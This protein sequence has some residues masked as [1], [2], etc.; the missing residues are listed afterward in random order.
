MVNYNIYVN[1]YRYTLVAGALF[2]TVAVVPQYRYAFLFFFTLVIM[3]NA[4]LR[5]EYFSYKFKLVSIIADVVMVLYMDHFFKGF[6]YLLLLVTLVDLMLKLKTEAFTIF[7]IVTGAYGY[8]VYKT[9]TPELLFIV[10][11][12]YIVT[13]LLL[14]HL[15]KEMLSKVDTEQLYDQI[16]KNNYEMEAAR[17]RLLDYSRQVERITKLEERNRISR[18][19]HDSIGHSLTG[20]FMQVDASIQLLE[21]DREKGMEVLRSAHDNINNAIESVRNTVRRIRPVDYQNYA[22][23]LNDLVD[24]FRKTTGVN[25]ELKSIGMPYELFP[26]METV[27]FRNVQEA[28]TNAVRHGRA[29]NILVHLVYKPD[30]VELIVSDDGPGCLDIKKGFGLSGIEERLDIIGGKVVYSGEKGFTVHMFLPYSTA[31]NSGS[32]VTD[33]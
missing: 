30:C 22:A 1:A 31:R 8:C 7:P 13:F 14:L 33:L 16:R 11:I 20:I 25:V 9:E 24:R 29:E 27:L 21:A 32:E 18:E 6:L 4:Q 5:T 26:S 17:A 28:L 10:S 2:G 12:L 19:L 15:R 3:T 23:S